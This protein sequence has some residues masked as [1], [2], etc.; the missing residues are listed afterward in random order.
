MSTL[1]YVTVFS[2]A[3]AYLAA[4]NDVPHSSL[5]AFIVPACYIVFVIFIYPFYFS[6]FRNLPEPKVSNSYNTTCLMISMRS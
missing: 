5:V 4:R 3:T 1:L 2:I 6:P